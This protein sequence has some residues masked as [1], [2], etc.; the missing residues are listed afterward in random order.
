MMVLLN[1]FSVRRRR[2]DQR[3]PAVCQLAA[4]RERLA[5][6]TALRS[7][8][9]GKLSEPPLSVGQQQ[10]QFLEIGLFNH[11]GLPRLSLSFGR[12]LG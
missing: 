2:G 11:L 6:Q 8:H 10:S 7:G 12:F 5:M 3:K 1:V 9:P 4:A